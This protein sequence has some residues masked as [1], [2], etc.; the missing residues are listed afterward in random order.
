MLEVKIL[1][2]LDGLDYR[3]EC[4][5]TRVAGH[6]S[7]FV[8]LSPLPLYTFLETRELQSIIQGPLCSPFPTGW[9]SCSDGDAADG[10][11]S[12]K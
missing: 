5:A 12:M 10:N 8:P 1:M 2:A 6:R 3:G 9:M 4:S 7:I 11:H